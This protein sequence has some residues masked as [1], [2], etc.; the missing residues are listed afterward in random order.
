M[1]ESF[2]K[3][4]TRLIAAIPEGKVA[5]YG[6]IAKLAGKPQGSRG[7]AWVLH[8]SSETHHLPWH[9]VLNSRGRISFPE[10][11]ALYMKQKR[12][13]KKEGV[14]FSPSGELDLDLYQ[15]KKRER[16]GK[17]SRNQ[18]RMFSEQK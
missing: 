14:F 7:V 5:S 2:A 10:G 3:A 4:V 13:L 16:A 9:R 17:K 6:Q 15:W 1:K 18:P 12:L 8:S 11:S